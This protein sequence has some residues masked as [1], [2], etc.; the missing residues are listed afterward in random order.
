MQVGGAGLGFSSAPGAAAPDSAPYEPPQEQ[1]AHPPGSV[2]VSKKAAAFEG[3]F[4]RGGLESTVSVS[5][6]PAPVEVSTA[7]FVATMCC[8][9]VPLRSWQGHSAQRQCSVVTDSWWCTH[10]LCQVDALPAAQS[11]AAAQHSSAKSLCSQFA[12]DAGQIA[13]GVTRERPASLRSDA[14]VSDASAGTAATAAR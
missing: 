3:A 5:A 11:H 8:C 6:P 10:T 9:L 12:S 4:A 2:P 14:E 7:L 1:P 13:S